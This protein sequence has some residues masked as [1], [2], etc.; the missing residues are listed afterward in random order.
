MSTIDE[1]Y[2]RY[3]SAYRDAGDADPRTYLDELRGV[4][5]AE[6][7]ARIDRFLDTAPPP[8]FDADAF[9]AFRA[10]P[11]RQ[12]LVT[13]MLESE[14]LADVRAQAAVTK[15]DVG[16]AL[17]DELG[18]APQANA[19]RARYHDVEVGNVDPGRV[20]ARVWDALAGILGASAE[21]LREAAERTFGGAW[22]QVGGAA[23]ARSESAGAGA[24]SAESGVA[25]DAGDDAVDRAFFDD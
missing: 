2:R 3:V 8:A 10:D 19:V 11:G 7:A 13:Q 1:L 25:G 23:F 5:R 9:A 16:A 24:L 12:A 22:G 21:R 15:R 18:L 4:D 14:T 20:T 17:A 6:L